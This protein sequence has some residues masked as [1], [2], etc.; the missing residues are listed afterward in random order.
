MMDMIKRLLRQMHV[1]NDGDEIK[2]DKKSPLMKRIDSTIVES[3]TGG[4]DISLGL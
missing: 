3:L 4:Q 1:G 2:H